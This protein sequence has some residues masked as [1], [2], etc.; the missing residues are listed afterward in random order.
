MPKKLDADRIEQARNSGEKANPREAEK[1]RIRDT[2]AR[3][4]SGERKVKVIQPTKKIY[5]FQE[6]TP[7]FSASVF[8]CTRT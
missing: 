5:A 1:S 3:N 8:G 6:A 7:S 2:I 4:R